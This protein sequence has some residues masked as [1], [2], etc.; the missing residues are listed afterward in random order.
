M[1][2]IVH[3][4]D[5]VTVAP[6][7]IGAGEEEI[8]GDILATTITNIMVSPIVETVGAPLGRIPVTMIATG[9]SRS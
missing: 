7:L 5:L 3:L 4:L 6:L 9:S 2:H 8:G 1:L